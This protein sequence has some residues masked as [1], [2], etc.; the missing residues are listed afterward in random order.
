MK[1]LRS[2]FE[3]Q[4]PVLKD[5][6]DDVARFL[7]RI[8][9]DGVDDAAVILTKP[10]GMP[11][12]CLL[13]LREARDGVLVHVPLEIGVPAQGAEPGTGSIDQHTIE[14]RGQRR[15][16]ASAVSAQ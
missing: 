7:A 5:I 6:L 15:M 16:R 10:D 1:H 12:E 11:Q 13:L 8:R 4:I 3:R 9:A 2:V 14:L